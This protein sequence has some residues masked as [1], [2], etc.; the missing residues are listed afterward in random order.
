MNF[1][2]LL[3]RGEEDGVL[4]GAVCPSVCCTSHELELL[5][6]APASPLLFS[7]CPLPW[8]CSLAHSVALSFLFPLLT[9]GCLSPSFLL[10]ATSRSSCF[11]SWLLS[12]P[13]TPDKARPASFKDS[14]NTKLRG[15]VDRDHNLPDKPLYQRG[16]SSEFTV[17]CG[18]TGFLS[19][20]QP[21]P[22]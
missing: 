3:K 8:C 2:P 18:V 9:F 10:P 12:H 21:V 17:P 22:Q 1:F 13:G 11:H 5:L 15:R 20:H 14:N 19:A 16:G 4:R 7:L 6:P